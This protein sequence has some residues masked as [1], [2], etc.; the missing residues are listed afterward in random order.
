MKVRKS[1]LVAAGWA[2]LTAQTMVRA[3]VPVVPAGAALPPGVVPAPAPLGIAPGPT[4]PGPVTFWQK[5]GVGKQQK[6]FCRRKLCETPLGGLINNSKAPLMALSGG[7]VQPFCPTMP[8]MASSPS[9]AAAPISA[10]SSSPTASTRTG[11]A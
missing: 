7:L 9:D 10:R 1:L 2:G 4:Q 5:L 8:S 3:Q 11:C 6:E